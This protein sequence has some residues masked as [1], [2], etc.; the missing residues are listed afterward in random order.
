MPS[1]PY[2]PT[3]EER[4]SHEATHIVLSVLGVRFASRPGSLTHTKH[5]ENTAHILLIEFDYALAHNKHPWR[6]PTV[7]GTMIAVVARRKSGQDD[8]VMQSFQNYLG[9]LGL[10]TAE[11]KCD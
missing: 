2:E 11:L 6:F 3:K 9:R 7:H 8:Y 10:V 5:L 4:Q 1:K